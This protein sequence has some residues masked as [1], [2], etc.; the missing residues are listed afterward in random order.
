[1][2]HLAAS[3]EIRMQG[4]RL[5]RGLENFIQNCSVFDQ[6]RKWCFFRGGLDPINRNYPIIDTT[7]IDD[8]LIR[9]KKHLVNDSVFQRES[10]EDNYRLN[11]RS[12]DII[13]NRDQTFR[14]VAISKSWI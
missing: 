3:Y 6:T 4:V 13:L 14:S 11:I 10:V 2:E 5:L 8:D 1:M 9:R 7:S 12:F